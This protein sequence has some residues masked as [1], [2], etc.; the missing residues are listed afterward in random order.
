MF[1]LQ[2]IVFI[3]SLQDIPDFNVNGILP[4]IIQN[5]QNLPEK[6]KSATYP[7]AQSMWHGLD[8]MMATVIL[9]ATLWNTKINLVC[10]SWNLNSDYL[11]KYFI[12]EKK[13]KKNKHNGIIIFK[14]TIISN[15]FV[16]LVKVINIMSH[17]THF[18]WH[19][20]T[21]SASKRKDMIKWSL[22]CY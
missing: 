8:P 13:C 11:P 2:V 22:N 14:Y 10:F 21:S 17:G 19:Q 20:I 15:Q 12:S 16:K 4:F 18:W 5:P 9:L 1:W 7:V 6:W 3:F